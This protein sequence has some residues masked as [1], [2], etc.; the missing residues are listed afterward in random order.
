MA[1][2]VKKRA[3]GA[4]STEKI[5]EA[6]AQIAGE[7]GYHG[8]TIKAVSQRSGLPASS[9][10]WHF[11]NKDEL[12][13]AVIDR[14]YHEWAAALDRTEPVVAADDAEA[15]LFPGLM[16]RVG[17]TLDEFGDFLRL[18]LLLILD[19]DPDEPT[20]RARFLEVRETSR[21]QLRRLYRRLFDDLDDDQIGRLAVLTLVL[22]DGAFIARDADHLDRDEVY[23]LLATAILG[24]AAELA[25]TRTV[26]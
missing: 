5:L 26:A 14:S 11:A 21:A 8:T 9:I 25:R 2:T 22:A 23:D 16:R 4:A 7:R 20:A 19:R 24:T 17:A 1:T 15:N 13:A 18:G 6:A 12:I 3:D 10:Y